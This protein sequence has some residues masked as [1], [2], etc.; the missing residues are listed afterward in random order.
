L[1]PEALSMR[2]LF[3]EANVLAQEA[4]VEGKME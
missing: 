3:T 4:A 1:A 2:D